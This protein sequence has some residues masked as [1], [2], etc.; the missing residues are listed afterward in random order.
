MQSPKTN[1]FPIVLTGAV[2]LGAALARAAVAADASKGQVT[3][4]GGGAYL[5]DGGGTH[6]TVGGNVGVRAS[7]V[8]I[9]GEFAYIPAPSLMSLSGYGTTVN[10]S[11]QVYDA[12]GGVHVD[13]TKKSKIV[14]Y[15]SGGLGWGYAEATVMARYFGGT[16]IGYE[17]LYTSAKALEYNGG[18]GVRIYAGKHWGVEPEVKVI[19]YT[20]DMGFTAVRFRAGLFLEFGK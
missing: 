18:F 7:R 20:G 8:L 19:R 6:A 1:Y 4:F 15:V 17:V 14:P 16:Y 2:L 3:V 9:L 11:G 10:V 12:S 5:S 13:L